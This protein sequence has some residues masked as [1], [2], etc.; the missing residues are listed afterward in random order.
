MPK[1]PKRPRDVNQWAKRMVDLATG[2][3]PAT[4]RRADRRATAIY[5]HAQLDS[6]LHEDGQ[7]KRALFTEEQNIGVL[8]EHEA[9]AKTSDLARR[10]ATR[11]PAEFLHSLDRE[12]PQFCAERVSASSLRLPKPAIPLSANFSHSAWPLCA[13]HSHSADCRG[14]SEP[15]LPRGIVLTAVG[16]KWVAR[17][18]R[19]EV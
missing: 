2:D 19:A 1:T 10:L 13:H 3:A 8:R 14:S 15:D 9:G 6:G 17:R 5:L 18:P 4:L 7:M 11:K 12:L 16:W